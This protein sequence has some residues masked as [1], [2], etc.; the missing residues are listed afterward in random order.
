MPQ[1]QQQA[2]DDHRRQRGKNRCIGARIVVKEAE[3]H[4]A[5]DKKKKELAEARNEVDTLVYSV[6]KSVTE[7]GS[8]LTEAERA[9]IQRALEE[10]K[11]VKDGSDVDAI[12][13]AVAELS[14]SSHKLAEEVYS[15]MN[16]EQAQSGEGASS[17]TAGGG[18][19]VASEKVV[20]AEFEE[21]DKDKK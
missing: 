19:N 20:D 1:P 2:D 9:D 18:G 7:Y 14:R 15:K 16:R 17:S 4:A 13:R 21:V 11:R 10:A 6:E 5:E 12:K 3:A 8:K